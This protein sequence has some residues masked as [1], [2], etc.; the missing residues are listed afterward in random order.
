M[1]AANRYLKEKDMFEVDLTCKFQLFLGTNFSN[2]FTYPISDK[3]TITPFIVPIDQDQAII[4]DR[5]RN[6]QIHEGLTKL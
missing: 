2:K 5:F 4:E 3:K 1:I 6:K